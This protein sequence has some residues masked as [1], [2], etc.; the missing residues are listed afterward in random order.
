MQV[1]REQ[2]SDEARPGASRDRAG[3]RGCSLGPEPAPSNQVL[4]A[5]VG[6]CVN[7]QTLCRVFNEL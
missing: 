1:I 4:T 6:R 7:E 3:P 2:K 5:P